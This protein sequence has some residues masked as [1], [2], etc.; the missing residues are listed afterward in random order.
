MLNGQ[1]SLNNFYNS[2]KYRDPL[3]A[4]VMADDIIE[5]A[6]NALNDDKSAGQAAAER[7]RLS[8]RDL[9]EVLRRVLESALT[10]LGY[11]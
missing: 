5:V 11:S 1:K 8:A 10:D 6:L 2:V 7:L 3:W 9:P 4:V